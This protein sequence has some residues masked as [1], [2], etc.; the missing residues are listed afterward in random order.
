M[1]RSHVHTSP[2]EPNFLDKRTRVWL[3]Q[4]KLDWWECTLILFGYSLQIIYFKA[5]QQW[6]ECRSLRNTKTTRKGRGYLTIC[7]FFV[8]S[9]RWS[10]VIHAHTLSSRHTSLRWR[11][12]HCPLSTSWWT[13]RKPEDTR[14]SAEGLEINIQQLVV[15]RKEKNKQKHTL[16]LV[17]TYCQPLILFKK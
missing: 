15:E 5:K 1:V 14:T 13:G 6:C 10:W 12:P 2:N 3:K 17:F 11:R 4:A 7:L 16:L 9:F 8:T